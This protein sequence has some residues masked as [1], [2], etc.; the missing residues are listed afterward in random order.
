[1]IIIKSQ[2]KVNLESLVKIPNVEME[3]DTIIIDGSALVNTLTP[4]IKTF[5][6]YAVRCASHHTSILNQ[7]H[8]NRQCLM[9]TN[10]QVSKMKPSQSV[11]ME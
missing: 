4:P 9:S 5:D 11:D 1:M 8:E 2:L 6:D 7:V 10:H 3:A